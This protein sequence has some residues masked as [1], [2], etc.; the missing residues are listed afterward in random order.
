VAGGS[1]PPDRGWRKIF[2]LQSKPEKQKNMELSN[3]SMALV[4]FMEF[5]VAFLHVPAAVRAGVS[6]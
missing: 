3:R 2:A 1:R 6:A 4:D 5:Q